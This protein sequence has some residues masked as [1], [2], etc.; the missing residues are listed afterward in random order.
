MIR[1]ENCG[2]RRSQMAKKKDSFTYPEDKEK[3]IN[4]LIE[5]GE[6]VVIGYEKYL[7]DEITYTDLAKIMLLLR[8]NLPMKQ[9]TP[10]SYKCSKARRKDKR[11]E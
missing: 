2:Q 8:E 11:D 5:I 9:E 1:V 10:R 4:D 3:C 6:A 7:L